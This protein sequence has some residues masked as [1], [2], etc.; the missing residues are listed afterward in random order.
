[1]GYFLLSQT[2]FLDKRTVTGD[3]LGSEV[4][5]QVSS[6][7]NHTEK[8]A[9]AVEVFFVDLQMLGQ[10]VD[11]VGQNGYL[12]LG[13]TGVTLVRLVLVNDLL[14][15]FLLHFLFTFLKIFERRILSKR[16]VMRRMAP[17]ARQISVSREKAEH[18]DYTTSFPICK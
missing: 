3:I 7:T 12:Y 17:W 15:D 14:L 13:R 18:C 1:L 10:G 2:Q 5:Q 9:V 8:T 6:L 16:Q 11:T 4:F